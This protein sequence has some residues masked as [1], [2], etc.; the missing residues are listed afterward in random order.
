M[1]I[2]LD[3]VSRSRRGMLN[4][5]TS[6]SMLLVLCVDNSVDGGDSGGSG[7]ES[8]GAV[9]VIVIVIVIIIFI[10]AF[11][12]YRQRKGKKFLTRSVFCNLLHLCRCFVLSREIGID[13]YTKDDAVLTTAAQVEE[14]ANPLHP[15]APAL[16]VPTDSA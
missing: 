3:N 15:L 13:Y 8:G 4:D 5:I 12:V 2:P 16:S 7:G 14:A 1:N 11:V 9:A 6:N 10:V